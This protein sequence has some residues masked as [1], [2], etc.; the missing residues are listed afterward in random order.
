[1][2]RF[3]AGDRRT[4]LRHEDLAAG[5]LVDELTRFGRTHGLVYQAG[6]QIIQRGPAGGAGQ[7]AHKL[8]RLLERNQVI[9]APMFAQTRL[10]IV[11]PASCRVQARVGRIAQAR[12]NGRIRFE[13]AHQRGQVVHVQARVALILSSGDQL[14]SRLG[15]QRANAAASKQAERCGT[16]G[17]AGEVCDEAAQRPRGAVGGIGDGLGALERGVELGGCQEERLA[18]LCSPP[19]NPQARTEQRAVRGQRGFEVGARRVRR[20]RLQPVAPGPELVEREQRCTEHEESRRLEAARSRTCHGCPCCTPG[21]NK[22][23]RRR[24]PSLQVR[25]EGRPGGTAY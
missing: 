14:Q 13:R 22:G 24:L 15:G 23:F 25:A 21:L 7:C 11:Q 5:E 2:D 12:A 4:E 6:G 8:R 16:R 1:M 3:L 17:H 18:Q 19:G 10:G 20:G 9:G